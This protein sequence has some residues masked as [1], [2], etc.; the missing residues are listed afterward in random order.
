MSTPSS[1]RVSIIGGSGYAGGELLRLLD[2]HPHATIAQITSESM[3]GKPV[4]IA[5]PNMR[6]RTSLTF[7]SIDDIQPCDLLFVC[8]PNGESQ[9]HMASLTSI[10]P[11][12]IDL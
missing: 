9:K 8:L 12:I 5:H 10:A 11:R 4:T 7:C 3:R 6:S 2:G 1:L